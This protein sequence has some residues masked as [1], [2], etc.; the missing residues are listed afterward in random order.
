MK[1]FLIVLSTREL[2]AYAEAANVA[3]EVLSGTRTVFAF[4]GESIEVNRYGKRLQPS[5]KIVARKGIFG[6][7]MDASMRL[8]YFITCALSFWFGI[9]WVLDDR[10]NQN[11]TYSISA[12][13]TVKSFQSQIFHT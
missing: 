3:E 6:S 2:N 9:K 7:I 10:K 8:L 4:G 13:T 12:F 1:Q 5:R 11:T